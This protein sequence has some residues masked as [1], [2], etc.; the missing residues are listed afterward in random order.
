M[1]QF[2]D[3]VM[4]NMRPQI[5]CLPL[6]L[7]LL[8][9]FGRYFVLHKLPQLKF[10]DTR[11]VT[12]KEASEARARGAFMKVLKPKTDAVSPTLLSAFQNVSKTV[13]YIDRVCRL[14]PSSFFLFAL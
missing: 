12:R 6:T 5:C 11:K 8:L 3:N 4:L 14:S 1:C 9:S 10:L 13:R 2:D 7:L